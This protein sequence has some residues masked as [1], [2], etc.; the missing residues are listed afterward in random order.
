M[1]T[2]ETTKTEL[3]KEDFYKTIFSAKGMT[4]KREL[5]KQMSVSAKIMLEMEPDAA[6]NVNDFIL[7]K[8]YKNEMHQTFN[9]FKNWKEKGF[10]VIE[11]SKAFFIW[12]RPRKVTKKKNEDGEKV[13]E[14]KMYGIAHLFS[15]AQV[16]PITS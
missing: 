13:D 3:S 12:S 1:N 11:G 9:T 4:E 10:S 6:D 8:M 16:K 5:L 15:N 2:E 14:F 7:N